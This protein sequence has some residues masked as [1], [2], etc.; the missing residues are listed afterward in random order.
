MF[1]DRLTDALLQ[2]C[3]AKNLSYEAAAELC[4]ISPR[5]FGDVVRK[6]SAPTIT[7]LEKICK[8]F[9][10]TPNELLGYPFPD[11]LRF[12]KSKPVISA[13]YTRSSELTV[14]YPVCPQCHLPIPRE[15]QNYCCVCGQALAW[16]AFDPDDDSDLI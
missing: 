11:D 14:I 16:D 5:Y 9:D 13:H 10:V 8:A 7:V 3:N 2:I 6:E 15:F 4:D 12:R 1:S